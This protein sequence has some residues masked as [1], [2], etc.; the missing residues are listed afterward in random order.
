MAKAH[1]CNPCIIGSNP[2]V[3]L[4]ACSSV[5]RTSALQAECRGFESHLVHFYSVNSMGECLFYKQ[6]V[7]GSSPLPSISADE[8]NRVMA[9]G[10]GYLV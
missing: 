8:S 3:T 9:L 6:K 4:W 1:G 10:D 2:I 5:G 7:S